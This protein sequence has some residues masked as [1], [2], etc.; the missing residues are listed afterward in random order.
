MFPMVHRHWPWHYCVTNGA[1][2]LCV[3]ALSIYLSELTSLVASLH[4]KAQDQH[5][6]R[7]QVLVDLE[8]R[9]NSATERTGS[10]NQPQDKVCLAAG[11]V[12]R[13]SVWV[14]GIPG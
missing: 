9:I 5:S 11:E 4:V 3:Y 2:R 10:W 12:A 13:P 6:G 7:P 8:Q 14:W 1:C